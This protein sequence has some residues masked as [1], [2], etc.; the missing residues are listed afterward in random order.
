MQ[1]G[2][3]IDGVQVARR[4]RLPRRARRM[5]CCL[6]EWPAL[7]LQI[8]M[9]S[10][11][12]DGE[13]CTPLGTFAS[14]VSSSSAQNTCVVGFIVRLGSEVVKKGKMYDSLRAFPRQ[15]GLSSNA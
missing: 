3:Q 7:S 10:L 11:S 14:V 6:N 4:C 2:E 8:Q 1:H 13:R 15:S 5:G 9:L 12:S